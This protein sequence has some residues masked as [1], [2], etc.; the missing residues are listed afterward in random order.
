MALLEHVLH[1]TTDETVRITMCPLLTVLR[2]V[3]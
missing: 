1:Q 2:I 3:R